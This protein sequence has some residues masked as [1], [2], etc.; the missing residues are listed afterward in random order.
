MQIETG[1]GELR[2]R[3][4]PDAENLEAGEQ[5]PGHVSVADPGQEFE[6]LQV[7]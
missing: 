5:N 7:T 2:M 4:T 6:K 3:Y 1:Y